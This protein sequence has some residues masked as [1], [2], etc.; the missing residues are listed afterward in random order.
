MTPSQRARRLAA[1]QGRLPDAE[2]EED[3][4][5]DAARDALVD[6]YT[7]ALELD[8][9][10]REVAVL[11]ELVEQAR[12]VRELGNDSKL[13]ALKQCLSEAQ[14]SELKDGRG[15]LLIFTEHRNTLNAVRENMVKWCYSTCE[16]HGG[17][18]PHERKR[19]Q[20]EF[21]TT[22]QICIATEAAGEGINL[23]FC[24]LM[25]NYDMPWPDTSFDAVITDT[26][27]YDNVSYSNLSDFFYM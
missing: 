3:D 22:A 8:Q 4:L 10:Q 24:H 16:I 12:R 14:F 2:Q 18:N 17:L 15:K 1:L 25:I 19:A 26:P 13:A 7:A 27:Y 6:E 23:Q 20:E 21:R 9:L 5:D 11:K